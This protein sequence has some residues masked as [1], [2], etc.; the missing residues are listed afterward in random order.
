MKV[1]AVTDVKYFTWGSGSKILVI[2]CPF[3]LWDPQWVPASGALSSLCPRSFQVTGQ[4]GVPW[5]RFSAFFYLVSSHPELA[6][7]Q[8]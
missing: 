1:G 2:N 6:L 5:P 4:A 7:V 8:K 3:A